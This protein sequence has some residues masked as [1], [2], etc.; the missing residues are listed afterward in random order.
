MCVDVDNPYLHDMVNVVTL[1]KHRS[2]SAAERGESECHPLLSGDILLLKYADK[3]VKTK[4][5][6][7][8]QLALQSNER[9]FVV[10]PG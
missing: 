2:V 9:A 6:N 7:Q 3:V 10:H 4:C 8:A 1:F 5:K